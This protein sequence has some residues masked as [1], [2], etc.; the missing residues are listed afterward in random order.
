M[1][2][3]EGY[4]YKLELVQDLNFRLPNQIEL[5]FGLSEKHTKFEKN[6]HHGFD[7]SA[8]LLSKRQNHENDF[9]ELCVLLKKS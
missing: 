8:D 1:P 7:K 2:A 5:K 6:L 4:I 9:F 3:M